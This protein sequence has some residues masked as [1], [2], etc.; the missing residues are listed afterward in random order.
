MLDKAIVTAVVRDGT[1]YNVIRLLRSL[2][3][4]DINM[5]VF[6]CLFDTPPKFDLI[7]ELEVCSNLLVNL[8]IR[9]DDLQKST[10]EFIKPIIGHKYRS[11]LYVDHNKWLTSIPEL[12][13]GIS[14][15][16][17]AHK[18]TDDLAQFIKSSVSERL[19]QHVRKEF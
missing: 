19:L 2:E 3:M 7:Q 18:M 5:H 15:F 6:V 16:S 14:V 10:I 17:D 9:P 4:I 12:P 8:D 11:I 13:Q 1:E